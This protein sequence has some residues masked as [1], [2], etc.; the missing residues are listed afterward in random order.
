M[1][2]EG[3]LELARQS[4]DTVHLAVAPGLQI[5]AAALQ[6]LCAALPQLESVTGA[7]PSW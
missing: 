4:Q 7:G 2:G 1:S 3:L 6:G 5:S